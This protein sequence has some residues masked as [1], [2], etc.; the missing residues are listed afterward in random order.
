[1]IIIIEDITDDIVSQIIE[2]V[3]KKGNVEFCH[4]NNSKVLSFDNLQIDYGKKIV[5]LDGNQIQ[6]NQLE[7]EVLYFLAS[8]PE[9]ILSRDQIF[10]RIWKDKNTIDG[11]HAVSCVVCGIRKKIGKHYIETVQNMGYRFV[12]KK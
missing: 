10:D 5:T 11:P 8:Y 6:F 4:L 1:M 12:V 2:Q 7:F 9:Y 3:S